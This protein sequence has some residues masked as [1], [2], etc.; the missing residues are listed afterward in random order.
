MKAV[1]QAGYYGK[2]PITI[3]TFPDA[4]AP[5]LA[6]VGLE[7]TCGGGNA[8]LRLPRMK[9]VI[10]R[11]LDVPIS[12]IDI[13]QIGHHAGI[14]TPENPIPW[15]VKVVVNGDDVTDELGG[16]EGMRKKMYRGPR[17]E[18]FAGTPPQQAT[19]ASFLANFL[20]VLFDTR[21]F[22]GTVNGIKGLQGGYPAI[23]GRKVE[24]ALPKE[25]RLAEAK[26]INEEAAK[27]DGLEE[28]KR[29]G[30]I[31]ISEKAN[32][33]LKNVLDFDYREWGIEE[34]VEL[35]LDLSKRFKKLKASFQR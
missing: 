15:W 3:A 4:V 6:N 19:S 14:G 18:A 35:A 31:V 27:W 30:T 8:Q 17:T 21:S 7:P 29:N 34:N 33:A 26:K 12:S 5:A 1:K 22:V 11:E 23:L 24:L 9:R 13:W 16:I 28:I 2:I 10:S 25:I 32:E 20:S